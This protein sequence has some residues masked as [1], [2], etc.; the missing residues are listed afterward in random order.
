MKHQVW[1]DAMNEEYES[2][3]KM[4]FGMWFLGPKTSQWSLQ[5]GFTKSNMEL[6]EV[7]R[8]SRPGSLLEAS[9]KRKIMRYMYIYADTGCYKSCH[10]VVGS[11][12]SALSL[13]I[14]GEA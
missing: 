11:I 9:L 5:N 8:S 6:M 7:L 1:K 3:I 13:Q 14:C 4:M 10:V 2:I 12:G